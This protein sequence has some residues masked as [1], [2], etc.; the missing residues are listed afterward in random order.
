[1]TKHIEW[2][3]LNDYVDDTLSLDSGAR[4]E[5]TGHLAECADCRDTLGRLRALL[6]DAADI[7]E[8]TPAQEAW[9]AINSAIVRRRSVRLADRMPAASLP[10]RRLRTWVAAAVLVLA[11]SSLLLYS[12]G[13][14]KAG[15]RG[16]GGAPVVASVPPELQRID[17][18]FAATASVLTEAM[19]EPRVSENSPGIHESLARSV[20]VLD[21]AIAEA[22]DA[23]A[24]DPSSELV[25]DALIRNY[26]QKIDLL[27]RV[28]AR[29]ASN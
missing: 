20:A 12:A 9:T 8:V 5:I 26:Q 24:K 1:M 11:A 18:E 25:R 13:V 22:R 21:T 16:A 17:N 15:K 23:L 27:R 14:S 4:Q 2:E 28:T 6:A 7:P 10:V 19:K 29:A 3:T